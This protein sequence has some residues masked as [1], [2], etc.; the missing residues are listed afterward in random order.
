VTWILATRRTVRRSRARIP[1]AR[2]VSI[3]MHRSSAGVITLNGEHGRRVLE[4]AAAR[5]NAENFDP[6][7]EVT[8]CAADYLSKAGRR[9]YLSGS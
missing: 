8:R 2:S 4:A 5:W 9:K 3:L 6:P 1:E 7:G